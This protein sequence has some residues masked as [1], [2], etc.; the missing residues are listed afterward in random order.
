MF[1]KTWLLKPA[2]FIYLFIVTL[3]ELQKLAFMYS[4]LGFFSPSLW[5]RPGLPHPLQLA[6]N[7]AARLITETQHPCAYLPILTPC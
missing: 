1:V 6:H 2:N 5:Y 4:R 3:T 7:A